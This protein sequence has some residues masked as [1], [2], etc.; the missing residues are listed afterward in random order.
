MDAPIFEEH[1]WGRLQRGIGVTTRYGKYSVYKHFS[2]GLPPRPPL[3]HA[4]PRREGRRWLADTVLA[5]HR[6]QE[7]GALP[8][9][10]PQGSTWTERPAGQCG[11]PHQGDGRRRVR[12]PVGQAERHPPAAEKEAEPEQAKARIPESPDAVVPAAP[13]VQEGRDV[14]E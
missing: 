9:R 12:G 14:G 3:L 4:P 7:G 8:E 13:L 1:A 6:L 5:G 2:P 11:Q 10:R